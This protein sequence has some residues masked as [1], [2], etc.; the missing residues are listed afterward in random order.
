ME[1]KDILEDPQWQEA[2]KRLAGRF[3]LT[4]SSAPVGSVLRRLVEEETRLAEFSVDDLHACFL[5]E[6]ER[7]IRFG[8]RWYADC[9]KHEYGEEWN[10]EEGDQQDKDR[11]SKVVGM[12]GGFLMG[13]TFLLLYARHK[14]ELLTAYIK[15]RRIPHAAKVAKDVKRVYAATMAGSSGEDYGS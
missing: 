3:G 9:N 10:P 5:Q 4:V 2:E 11:K 7:V 15:R 13:Y 14:P 12:S 6:P 8:M 1:T